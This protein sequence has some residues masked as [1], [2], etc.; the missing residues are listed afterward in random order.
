MEYLKADIESLGERTSEEIIK[1]EVLDFMKACYQ[2]G[3]CSG[4]CPSGRRTAIRTRQLIRESLLNIEKVL[5]DPDIWMCTT[6]FTCFERCPRSLPT[7]NIILKLRNLACQR[8]F[9]MASHKSLTHI[10]FKTGHGVPLGGTDN[11]W[12]QARVSYGLPKIPPTTHSHPEAVK[13]VEL[14]MKST[15]F[16]KLVDYKSEETSNEQK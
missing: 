6:C 5:A 1:D 2:C 10:L 11:K 13:E 4:S 12:T 7:T 15:N 8:G 9:M 16:D 3:T 14:L